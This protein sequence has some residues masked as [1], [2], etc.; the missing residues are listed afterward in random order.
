M[1]TSSSSFNYVRLHH[2]SAGRMETS[3]P[4]TTEK[5]R[6]L[7]HLATHVLVVVDHIGVGTAS[8]K[9]PDVSVVKRLDTYRSF[10]LVG[11]KVI[12][13]SRTLI[14]I[15]RQRSNSVD[16][17]DESATLWSRFKQSAEV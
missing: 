9:S 12:G 11:V 4:S 13:D 3:M 8:S 6:R 5:E 10:V 17:S 16:N 7:R 2:R 14:A 1:P 15:G